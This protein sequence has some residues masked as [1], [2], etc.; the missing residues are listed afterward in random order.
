MFLIALKDI[1]I[2]TRLSLVKS[3]N[4]YG[5]TGR[6]GRRSL[7]TPDTHRFLMFRA[8]RIAIIQNETRYLFRDGLFPLFWITAL[9]SSKQTNAR[10]VTS[11]DDKQKRI[12]LSCYTLYKLYFDHTTVH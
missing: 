4:E 1:T 2:R 7:K 5:R 9:R 10:I 8:W 12:I 11:E 6:R 3:D